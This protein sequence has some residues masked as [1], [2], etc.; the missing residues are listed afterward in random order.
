MPAVLPGE[1]VRLKR[2]AR[3]LDEAPLPDRADDERRREIVRAVDGY[4]LP[5][6]DRPDAPLVVAI[7]GPGG[8]GK[9][10][11]VNQI[12]GDVH[13]PEGAVRPTTTS[14]T[15][16]VSERVDPSTW[17][18]LERRL[19]AAAPSMRVARNGSPLTERAILVDLPAADGGV[20]ITRT[21]GLA[22]LVLLVVTPERYADR[23]A[24]A[25]LRRLHTTG[26]AVWIVVNRTRG[27][28]DEVVTDLAGR[29]AAAGLTV[30]VFAV[31]EGAA[32]DLGGLR[33]ALAALEGA[34]RDRLLEEA[35]TARMDAA[36]RAASGL[37]EPL[38]NLHSS[39]IEL[40]AA[41]GGEY[42][43]AAA[44]VHGH[45]ADEN[46]LSWADTSSWAVVA[47]RLASVVTRTIGAAAGHTAAAWLRNR[48]GRELI[49]A[50]GQALWRH[51]PNA[52]TEARVRLLRWEVEV[53]E[54]VDAR[55]RRTLSPAK[56]RDVRMAV[57]QRALGD[58][59]KVRWRVR[60]RLRGGIEPAAEEAKALLATMAARIVRDDAQRFLERLGP[61]PSVG[62]IAELVQLTEHTDV[63]LPDVDEPGGD[64]I[65]MGDGMADAGGS[66]DA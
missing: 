1:R 34:A 13:C 25:L 41:A 56:L 18:S 3:L 11:I 31:A 48:G 36:F 30:P 57:M 46:L 10:H 63:P 7:A 33:P 9:S 16:V 65:G 60:R 21:L 35:V 4:L 28:D 5:R 42:E 53:A 52:S 44:A 29:L 20:A 50:E 2:L 39:G 38:Q 15:A 62:T 54:M 61:R 27:P 24:W 23:E 45:V 17:G 59:S 26:V 55:A 47:D 12:T 6:L 40:A 43:R 14:P 19:R 64:Q 49:E 22:D 37:R 51:A 66:P 8:S 32:G 58:T